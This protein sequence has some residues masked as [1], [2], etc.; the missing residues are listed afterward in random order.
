MITIVTG[1]RNAYK[2]TYLENFV[3]DM[4]NVDGIL[5]KKRFCGQRFDG[6]FVEHIAS[7]I[8]D[9]FL[10]LSVPSDE[11]IGEFYIQRKG[12]EFAKN[13]IRRAILENKVV[14]IDELG[15]A[16]LS[17]RLFYDELRLLIS[18]NVDA[19]LVIRESLLTR[20]L[21]KFPQLR[22][23]KIIEVTMNDK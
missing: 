15:Q 3:A 8:R 22:R 11:K 23:A 7:G 2:T 14:V 6:Y 21:E 9:E 16:E 19:V 5:S 18:K 12:L 20:Y 17:E 13:R 10:S 1:S 4:E